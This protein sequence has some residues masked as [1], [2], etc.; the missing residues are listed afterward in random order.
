MKTSDFLVKDTLLRLGSSLKELLKYKGDPMSKNLSLHLSQLLASRLCHDL[1]APVGALNLGI[2]YLSDQ[3]SI[4]AESLEMLRESGEKA[5]AK[6]VF[7]RAAF[8]F[9]GKERSISERD[10]RH[11]MITLANHCNIKVEWG[12]NH[13]EDIQHAEN[14]IKALLTL[15][16]IVVESMPKGGYIKIGATPETGIESLQS[17]GPVITVPQDVQNAFSREI[18]CL[19]EVTPRTTPVFIARELCESLDLAP[20]LQVED[21][22]ELTITFFK[23]NERVQ[24][25]RA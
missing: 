6:L 7:Y 14:K 22:K 8:G 23:H 2:D 3:T 19:E 1:I 5:S 11:A 25:L 15:F 13:A 20:S 9:L 17:K 10:A 24:H 16:L 21:K 4:N 18:L 12:H